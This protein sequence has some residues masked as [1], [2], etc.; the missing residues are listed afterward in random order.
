MKALRIY[1]NNDQLTQ[2]HAWLSIYFSSIVKSRSN[3]FLEATSTKYN[4]IIPVWY[5][6][7]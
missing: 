1:N 2:F 7:N 3:T 4:S 6:H 5:F